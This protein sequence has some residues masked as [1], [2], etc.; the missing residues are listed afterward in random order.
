MPPGCGHAVD[1]LHAI[2]IKTLQ[3]AGPKVEVRKYVD[4]L[5]AKGKNFAVHL[6]QA[7]RRVH[8]SLTQANMKV[9]LKKT[10]VPCNGAKA[11]RL[12]K[13]VWKNGRLPPLKVTTRDLGV[14]TQWAAWRCPVQRKRVMTFNQAMTRVRSKGLRAVTKA[15]IA[16]SLYSVGLYGLRADGL[17]RTGRRPTAQAQHWHLRVAPGRECL[18]HRTQQRQRQRTHKTPK[19]PGEPGRMSASEADLQIKWDSAKALLAEV[20]KKRPDFADQ[21]TSLSTQACRHLKKCSNK[22]DERTRIA[23]NAALGGVWACVAALWHEVRTHKAFTVGEICIRC[24]EEPEDLSHI[25]FRC[26]HCAKSGEKCNSQRTT[27]LSRRVSSC[28][29]CFLR[30]RCRQYL[31]MNLPWLTGQELELFGLRDLADDADTVATPSAEGGVGYYT[32]TQERVWL[33]LPG[34]KQ[35]VYR[36]E[37]LAVVRA[38]EGGASLANWTQKAQ[39]P[40]QRP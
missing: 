19:D 38:L 25:L 15:R 7:Y 31:S 6:C 20:T 26:P 37:F 12:V 8:R 10:V 34:L 18:G 14:Y 29:D 36:A 1:L 3:I 39:G 35:F 21:E 22:R 24:Q 30:Q 4:V 11:K 17:R 16:K 32:D 13:K 5:V 9:N 28:M 40:Q 2:L 23:V 27:T 33:P